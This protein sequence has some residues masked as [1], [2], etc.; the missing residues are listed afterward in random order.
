MNSCIRCNFTGHNICGSGLC[1]LCCSENNNACFKHHLSNGIDTFNIFG[2]CNVFTNNDNDD[3]FETPSK[4]IIERYEENKL[5]RKICEDQMDDF[6]NQIAVKKIKIK[7]M[8]KGL[9]DT[10]KIYNAMILEVNDLDIEIENDEKIIRGDKEVDL[11]EKDEDYLC[12]I[13][14]SKKFDSVLLCGH[15]FCSICITDFHLP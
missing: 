11:N 13:C 4:K 10:E 6:K 9:E 7:Y 15:V 1:C 5:K 12:K 2:F 14:C 8:N 3:V